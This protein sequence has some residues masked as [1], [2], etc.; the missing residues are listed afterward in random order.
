MLD[1]LYKRSTSVPEPNSQNK[2]SKAWAK[3]ARDAP[4]QRIAALRSA[5]HLMVTA[6]D[7]G[8]FDRG[9]FGEPAILRTRNTVTSALHQ[10][11]VTKQSEYPEVLFRQLL[12]RPTN[13]VAPRLVHEEPK[14]YN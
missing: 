2:K 4:V 12:V 3:T 6:A 9:A 1:N 10:E 8:E 13:R 7:S 14:R 5:N 11:E